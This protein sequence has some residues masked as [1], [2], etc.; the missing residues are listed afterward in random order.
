M[1]ENIELQYQR[2]HV[3]ELV[4]PQTAETFATWFFGLIVAGLLAWALSTGFRRRDWTPL[5]LLIVGTLT[6]FPTEAFLGFLSNFTHAQIGAHVGYVA[7]ARVVPV[8]MIFV[9]SLYF[10]AWYMFAYP[11]M[12]AGTMGG[13]FL[14]KAFF[15]SVVMAYFFEMIPIHYGMWKY[16]DPQPLYFFKGAMPITYAFLNSFCVIFG[17]ILIDKL[18]SLPHPWRF[19]TMLFVGPVGPVMGHIGAGQGYFWTLNS[20]VSNYMVDIGGIVSIFACLVGVS[21]LVRFAYPATTA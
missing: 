5:I 19:P 18:R 11:R 7:Y 8:F 3:P 21:L 9:Y 16:F 12:L 10:G 14:W 15:A 13:S 2:M 17:V 20:T 1:N 4:M 6:C